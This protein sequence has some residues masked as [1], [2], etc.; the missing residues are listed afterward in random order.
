MIKA[1]YDALWYPALPFVMAT[2]S[3][4]TRRGM[5]ERLG[6]I[7]SAL[8][9]DFPIWVHAAS[10]GE[11]G[12]IAAVAQRVSAGIPGSSLTVT[13]MT[14]SGRAAAARRIPAASSVSLAPFDLGPIVRRFTERLHQRLLLI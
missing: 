13:T 3:G 8:R 4:L 12:A 2:S 7:E 5:K 14:T 9:S 11:V 1:V 10:V 6:I